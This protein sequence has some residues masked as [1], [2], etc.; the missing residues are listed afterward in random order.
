MNPG[1]LAPEA[2][3][4]APAAPP[5]RRR[6]DRR[7]GAPSEKDR[8]TTMLLMAAL[9]HGVLIL[10]VRFSVGGG[11]MSEGVG[12]EVLLVSEELPE[13]RENPEARYLAQ[14]SQ[15][16]SGNTTE[17]EAAR[18]PGQPAEAPPTPPGSDDPAGR[19]AERL[20]QAESGRQVTAFELDPVPEPAERPPSQAAAVAEPSPAL[21]DTELTL[22]GP[23]RDEL[24]VSPDTRR[25][26]LAPYLAAWKRRVER[27]GTI[28]YPSAAQRRGLAGNPVIEVV[29]GEDGSLREARIRR[30]SGHPEIDAAALDIL[31]LASPFD[32][33]P[34]ALAARHDQLRFAYEWQF[35]GGRMR[36][37][38][39]VP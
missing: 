12:M 24:Y 20:L 2:L 11:A 22:R 19:E 9:L 31:R 6:S 33:F 7:R 29:L 39:S 38:V 1:N 35:E 21:P 8:L 30:S 28:N 4:A 18:V 13:S 26:D 17:R 25:S 14:R 23:R 34:P 27:I 15:Q 5:A 32:A 3:A 37:S 36:G 16:G 10:G